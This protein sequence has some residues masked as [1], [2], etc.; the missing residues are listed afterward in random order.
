MCL[1]FNKCKQELRL[2]HHK[3]AG[4]GWSYQKRKKYFLDN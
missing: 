4:S 3:K 2:L 1:F